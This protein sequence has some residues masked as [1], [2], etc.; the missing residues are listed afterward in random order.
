MTVTIPRL[1]YPNWQA[2]L[3][4]FAQRGWTDGLPILPPT[5]EAVATLVA[6]SGREPG[7]ELGRVPPANRVASVEGIAV[8]AAMTGLAPQL[9]PVLL[10]AV[11]ALLL[12]EFN[13]MAVQCTTNPVTPLVVVSAPDPSALGLASGTGV[14]G[15]G[16]AGN[17]T[18]GRALRLCMLNLGGALPGPAD[19][20]TH[21]WPGK[22]ACCVAEAA[23]FHRWPPL[24]S[25]LG[26]APEST[27]VTLFPA[28]G[29]QNILD[30]A[31][32]DPES[33]LRTF[34]HSL[35][36]VG[37][38]N[39]LLG[40]GPCLIL[41]PEHAGVFAGGGLDPAAVAGR[42]YAEA[43]VPPDRFSPAVVEQV[44]RPRRKGWQ[45]Q[46]DADAVPVADRPED[47][48]LVVAGGPGPHSL[49]LHSF[50]ADTQ[51]VTRPVRWPGANSRVK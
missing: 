8:N 19:K 29:V 45:P 31:S 40:G 28:T 17:A 3:A 27:T 32:K 6:A 25:R 36:A 42:L 37:N 14:F 39:L 15:A 46:S 13:A 2:V 41:G 9:F 4:D 10:A 16:H 1:T 22:F 5:A 43:R 18:V 47:F 44:L 38:N 24:R 23:E 11:E 12:P 20:A 51:P 7:E 33:L 34:C 49:L 35:T 30:P 21:G 48:L 26:H 50:G